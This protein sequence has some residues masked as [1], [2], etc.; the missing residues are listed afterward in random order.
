MADFVICD[1]G[2][3]GCHLGFG[4]SCYD[5][6][7]QMLVSLHSLPLKTWVYQENLVSSL[8][9][10]QVMAD[11]LTWHNGGHLGYGGICSDRKIHLIVPLQSLP[12][13][14]WV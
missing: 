5:R 4:V 3:H 1:N 9:T 8:H 12:S 14:T 2:G 13:K 7:Q 11:F 10:F 6:R